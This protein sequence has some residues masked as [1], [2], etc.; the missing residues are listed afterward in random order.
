M[1]LPWRAS[2]AV[3]LLVAILAVIR[4]GVVESSSRLLQQQQRDDLAVDT[5]FSRGPAQFGTSGEDNGRRPLCYSSPDDIGREISG[6]IE[7][8]PAPPPGETFSGEQLQRFPYVSAGYCRTFNQPLQLVP[9]DC[10][11]P[12][13][14]PQQF[15]EQFRGHRLIF[16]GDSVTRQFFFYMLLRLSRQV[17]ATQHTAWRIM[18][19]HVMN[20]RHSPPCSNCHFPCG[21]SC[22]LNK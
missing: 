13:F 15:I 6:S 2:L 16:W 8:A 21:I 7:N 19:H 20:A 17:P 18:L 10:E 9:T 1:E 3:P 14:D 12:G 4:A 5:Q 11:L 22:C